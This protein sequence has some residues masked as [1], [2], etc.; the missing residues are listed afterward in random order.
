MFHKIN[1]KVNI[2]KVDNV[3]VNNVNDENE[4]R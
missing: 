2:A 1:S 3:K 4:R